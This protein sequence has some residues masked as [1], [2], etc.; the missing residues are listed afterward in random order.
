MIDGEPWICVLWTNDGSSSEQGNWIFLSGVLI[1]TNF[2]T[3]SCQ[4]FL[5]ESVR[6][7]TRVVLFKPK[8]HRNSISLLWSTNFSWEDPNVC[9]GRQELSVSVV[10]TRR[11]YWWGGVGPQGNK[12][13][14]VSSDDV[15]YREGPKVWCLGKGV[16]YHVTM[17]PMMHVMYLTLLQLPPLWTDRRLWKHYLAANSFA[18]GNKNAFQ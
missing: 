12:F 3:Y 6:S 13:E 16:P 10:T 5:T 18:G 14:Q 8:G 9:G 17:W 7:R 11:Q 2:L 4:W 1:A 15:S